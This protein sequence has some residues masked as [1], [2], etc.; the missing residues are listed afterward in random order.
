MWGFPRWS[1]RTAELGLFGCIAA[2]QVEG[3]IDRSKIA[4]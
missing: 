1:H 2:G 4:L 3:E